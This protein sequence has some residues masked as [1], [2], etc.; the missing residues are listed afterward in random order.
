MLLL[1]DNTSPYTAQLLVA[2]AVN[3]GYELPPHPTYSP[4][5]TRTDF[6]LFPHLKEVLQGNKY[7][8]DNAVMAAVEDFLEGHD[9]ELYRMGKAKLEDRWMKCIARKGDY[10]RHRLNDRNIV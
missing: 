3:C 4:D 8:N 2:T 5:V 6:Y 10:V 7:E 1:Q 9:E